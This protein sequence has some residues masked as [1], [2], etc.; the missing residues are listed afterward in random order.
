MAIHGVLTKDRD[1]GLL[2][3]GLRCFPEQVSY[4]KQQLLRPWAEQGLKA[5]ALA[6]KP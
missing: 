1:F 3:Y 6:N 5:K 4:L 2:W